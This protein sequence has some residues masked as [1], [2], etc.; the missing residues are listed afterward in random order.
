MLYCAV[1]FRIMRIVLYC[2]TL[3]RSVCAIFLFG[4]VASHLVVLRCLVLCPV[5]LYVLC[6]IVYD[7]CVQRYY[8]LSCRVVFCCSVPC[9]AVLCS[10]VT[11]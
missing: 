8:V 2:V 10:A 4:R 6:C 5:V 9:C 7:I 11:V 3:F 1:S